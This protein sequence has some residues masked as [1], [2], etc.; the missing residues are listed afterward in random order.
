MATTTIATFG[1]GLSLSAHRSRGRKRGAPH[2]TIEMTMMGRRT[3]MMKTKT[4]RM[5][6]RAGATIWNW[7][8]EATSIYVA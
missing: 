3:R 1:V 8:I 7:S 2:A 4:R 6:M 5:T